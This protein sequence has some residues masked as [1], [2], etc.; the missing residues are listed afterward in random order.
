MTGRRN[1]SLKS[2]SGWRAE[3]RDRIDTPPYTEEHGAAGSA[4]SNKST[5]LSVEFRIPRRSS[6]RWAGRG[7]TF[8]TLV[9][10]Q[11]DSVRDIP[12][13]GLWI[14][15]SELLKGFHKKRF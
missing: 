6:D 3:R 5:S 10:S 4:F 15:V 1:S 12:T 9:R 8:S 14:L 13:N 7:I 11:T 2:G